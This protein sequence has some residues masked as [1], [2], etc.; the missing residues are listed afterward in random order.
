MK[1]WNNTL[2][3]IGL[4]ISRPLSEQYEFDISDL[5]SSGILWSLEWQ[6]HTDASGLPIQVLGLLEP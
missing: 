5:H 6:F 4:T 1:I 3:T 2:G